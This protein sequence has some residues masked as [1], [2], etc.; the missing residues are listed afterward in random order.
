MNF[1]RPTYA[2]IAGALLSF[3]VT[4]SSFGALAIST[5]AESVVNQ[6]SNMTL[7]HSGKHKHI[8]CHKRKKGILCHSH[9][10]R[11]HSHHG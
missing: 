8:H 2:L 4:G 3:S 10:H 9:K 11:R 6:N 5:P 7:A 1:R